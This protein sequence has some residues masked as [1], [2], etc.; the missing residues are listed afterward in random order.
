[1]AELHEPTPETKSRG[2]VDLARLEAT[3]QAD[4]RRQ[5]VEDGENPEAPMKGY[6]VLNKAM[7]TQAKASVTVAPIEIKADAEGAFVRIKAR[8]KRGKQ[9]EAG[10]EKAASHG[11]RQIA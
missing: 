7:R 9:R 5:M 11:T 2:R 1:M 8:T 3:T 4:I 6:R 10:R